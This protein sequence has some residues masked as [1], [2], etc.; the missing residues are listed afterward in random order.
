M[1]VVAVVVPDLF[2]GFTDQSSYPDAN[3]G[4]H[5]VHQTESRDEFEFVDVQLFFFFFGW[6]I[7]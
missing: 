1:V 3:V 6:L 5:A 7:A 2:E 4:G